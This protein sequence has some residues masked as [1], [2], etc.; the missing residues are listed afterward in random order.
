MPSVPWDE[1]P[2]QTMWS[3]KHRL[4]AIERASAEARKHGVPP[5]V[6][7]AVKSKLAEHAVHV[8]INE[9]ARMYEAI[10]DD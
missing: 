6:V 2:T 10:A 1:L 8:A 9:S 3:L 4:E 5:R 7:R